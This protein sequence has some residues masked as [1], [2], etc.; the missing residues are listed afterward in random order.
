MRRIAYI[1]SLAAA[2]LGSFWLTLWYID[3]NSSDS[4]DARPVIERLAER[5]VSSYGDL[6]RAAS[7]VGLRHSKDME[8][9]VDSITRVN[10][11]DVMIVGWLADPEGAAAP[12]TIIVYVAGR[13]VA[14]TQTKGERP[15]VTRAKN[16]GFGTEKDVAFQVNVSCHTGE[17]PVLVGLGTRNQYIPLVARPCP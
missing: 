6:S 13:V 11:R 4:T 1:S 17:Q 8:G 7:A 5:Q 15:D 14:R 10:E 9:I 16:L 3:T 2:F 12:M